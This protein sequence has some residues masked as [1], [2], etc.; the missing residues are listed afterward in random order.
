MGCGNSRRFDFSCSTF[1][2]V[3][4]ERLRPVRSWLGANPERAG[5]WGP[6]SSEK[7]LWNRHEVSS[8]V[9]ESVSRRSQGSKWGDTGK[10][11][12]DDGDTY[13]WRKNLSQDFAGSIHESAPSLGAVSRGTCGYCRTCLI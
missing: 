9:A 3:N 7:P 10:S 2:R 11:G 6:A 8:K 4:A 5:W 13:R 1:W 12:C